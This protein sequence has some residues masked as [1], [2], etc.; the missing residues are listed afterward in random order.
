MKEKSEMKSHL[1]AN[2]CRIDQIS[3]QAELWSL[4]QRMFSI[5]SLQAE[6]RDGSYLIRRESSGGM[7][8]LGVWDCN[9]SGSE[10]SNFGA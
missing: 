5:L 9:F 8:W 3:A 4:S 1:A 7:E 2:M 6:A 10:F